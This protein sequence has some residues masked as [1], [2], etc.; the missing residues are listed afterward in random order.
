MVTRAS[1]YPLGSAQVHIQMCEKHD[2]RIDMTCE[3]CDKFICSQCAKTD[4]KDHDW[5]T[6]P[7]AGSLRRRE[8]N[9]ILRK[10]KEEDVKEMDEKIEKAA[11]QMEDNQKCCNSKVSKLQKQFD[12]IVSKLDEIKKNLETELRECLVRKNAKVSEK[13]L[14]L[15]RNL[16]K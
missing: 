6:I 3:D 7:T 5:K 11:K 4:H 9:E 2:L 13:K 15:K 12:E 10:I 14:D 8:L 16:N 1:E